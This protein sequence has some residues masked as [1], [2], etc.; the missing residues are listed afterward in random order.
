MGGIGKNILFPMKL[1]RERV[2]TDGILNYSI[3]Y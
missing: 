3:R 1:E 2:I